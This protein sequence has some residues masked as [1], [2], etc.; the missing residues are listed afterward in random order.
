M[1]TTVEELNVKI[2]ADSSVAVDSI[3]RLIQSL[4]RLNST[5]LGNFARSFNSLKLDNTEQLG[6]LAK[7]LGSLGKVAEQYG[8]SFQKLSGMGY[9]L[10][11]LAQVAS[12][13]GDLSNITAF[14]ASLSRIGKIEPEKLNLIGDAFSKMLTTI[15][16]TGMPEDVIRLISELA[17][18]I[19][20]LASKTGKRY[21]ADFTALTNGLERLF[22]VLARAPTVSDGTIRLVE[23]VSKLSAESVKGARGL[24]RLTES[25]ARGAISF[26]RFGRNVGNGSATVKSF[27]TRL[28]FAIGKF[29]QI[30]FVIRRVANLFSKMVKS[31][32]EYVETLNY[33]NAAFDQVASRSVDTFGDAGQEAGSAFA[34][35]F[36]EEAAK[37]TEKMSGYSV[38]S[39]GMVTN[40]MGTTLGMNPAAMMNYQA[41]FA[42]MAS[43]MGVSSEMA[44]DLSRALTEIGADLASVKNLGFEDTWK[45]LQSGLVGM[46]RAVDKYGLNIRNVNLQ[47]KLTQLGIEANIQEMNQQDK[48]LL[49]TI[50]ILEN[51]QYAWGDLADTLQQP[52]NQV[53][54]LQSGMANLGR[55]IGNLLLPVVAAAL[56][57]INAF[58][59]AL[60]KMVE[61]L[62]T[63][64]GFEFDWGS[65]GG[66]IIDSE[67]ADYLDDTADSLG[68]ATE[69]AE[70]WK[71]QLLG[72]DEINK[73]GSESSADSGSAAGSALIT[74]QLEDALRAALDA[75]QRVW[76]ASYAN[77]NN[78]VNEM[79]QAIVDAF[80][81][82][83]F[84]AIGQKV[85]GWIVDGLTKVD[86][87]RVKSF[88]YSVGTEFANF[89]NGFISPELFATA[90]RTIAEALNTAVQRALGFGKHFDWTNFG[91]S[92]GTGISEFLIT[93]NFGE[94]VNA[95]D[96]FVQGFAKAIIGALGKIRWGEIFSNVINGLLEL[97]PV[98]IA[99]VVGSLGIKAA[100]GAAAG[101]LKQLVS[102]LANLFMFSPGFG[103]ALAGGAL[104][105]SVALNLS[106]EKLRIDELV[107]QTMPAV[108]ALDGLARNLNDAVTAADKL[109][110]SA[111]FKGEWLQGVADEYRKL[112][113]KVNLTGQEEDRLREL[114]GLLADENPAFLDLIE[115]QT[116][117]WKGTYE[118]LDQLVQ[119]TREY[120]LTMAAEEAKSG[121]YST[122]MEADIGLRAAV[123]ERDAEQKQY[124]ELT[125]QYTALTQA[126]AR[127]DKDYDATKDSE[128]IKIAND[129]A[130]ALS[131]VQAANKRIAE[132]QEQLNDANAAMEKYDEYINAMILQTKGL[133]QAVI[134]ATRE[135]N[136]SSF[137]EWVDRAVKDID[138]VGGYWVQGTNGMVQVSGEASLRIYQAMMNGDLKK[139]GPGMYQTAMGDV[140]YYGNGLTAGQKSTQFVSA[141]NSFGKYGPGAMRD[142]Y[143]DWQEAGTQS[144][145][146]TA[147]GFK[148]GI[149]AQMNSVKQSGRSMAHAGFLKGFDEAM[150]IE[151]PSKAME[152][153]GVYIVQGLA[154]GLSNTKP[155]MNP[156][157]NLFN[158]ITGIFNYN[159]VRTGLGGV[160]SAFNNAFGDAANAAPNQYNAM[161][162]SMNTATV[163]KNRAV[164]FSKVPLLKYANGGFPPENGFFFANSAELVGRFSNGRT[165]VANNEQ[166]IQGIE[167][168]VARGMAQ[169][170]MSTAN[171]TGGTN[172]QPVPVVITV[173]SEILYRATLRGESKY[174]NRYHMTVR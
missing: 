42:Q 33:F 75:Y 92:I 153:R 173:D 83:D 161:A 40:T 25:A 165:A 35:R 26:L 82:G 45:N 115:A 118:Q 51:S 60:Q 62:V 139:I 76:D 2:T 6:T 160:V 133:S 34:N 66:A 50:I 67:W 28:A 49:R 56:P 100:A 119:K 122:A 86:W 105:L 146:Y 136:D 11:H 113:E 116:G 154:N 145:N 157:N 120:Y 107:R 135:I 24:I 168:G 70:E 5:D 104:V 3:D 4:Q 48:A 110:S 159:N 85:S 129:M 138:R 147:S 114:A 68:N 91:E 148:K 38:T 8:S 172:G 137:T 88:A 9:N 131:K 29:R 121:Y 10:A 39:S 32:M 63:A 65:G 155:L 52:A 162:N 15:T 174:N 21:E 72:F 20:T 117:K 84:F 111:A 108:T 17:T 127:A 19:A 16:S 87:D 55:T 170:I 1:P 27:T 166:I 64:M 103:I 41:T 46:S 59:V 81:E 141:V 54:M 43:S 99:L 126:R 164:N 128:A 158:A 18:A 125:R 149:A 163:N 74:G 37:L 90:G 7:R 152:Q 71:N 101:L 123:R 36:A 150:L 98:T 89:L 130:T 96:A 80:K 78:R 22:Q 132:F 73:L 14:T 124:E 44:T 58:V 140:I 12:G 30:Y 31:S 156:L 79:A 93:F 77:V 53:R 97:D 94:L 23:A 61:L 167:G 109:A 112:N 57:Y 102:G 106:I 134:E 151:S 142:F 47:Q 144:A 13:I 95:F 169:A 171:A 69:A 143:S